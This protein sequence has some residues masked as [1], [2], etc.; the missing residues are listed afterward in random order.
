[1]KGNA[2]EQG[3]RNVALEVSVV[4][5]WH[6]RDEYTVGVVHPGEYL[7]GL[8]RCLVSADLYGLIRF[9][10]FRPWK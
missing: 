10:H 5:Y 4:P 6:S 7:G 1:M 3:L 2:I 9:G 8:P